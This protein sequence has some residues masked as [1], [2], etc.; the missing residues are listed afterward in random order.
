M[1]GR[2]AR[3]KKL[4]ELLK[5]EKSQVAIRLL[6]EQL[7]KASDDTTATGVE[8]SLE[9]QG[10]S[11]D[12]AKWGMDQKP[13][14]MESQESPEA[15]RHRAYL[16]QEPDTHFL[17]RRA[18]HPDSKT[19]P[20]E[21]Y[22]LGEGLTE[23]RAMN[24]GIPM[25]SNKV[26]DL[27]SNGNLNLHQSLILPSNK[28]EGWMKLKGHPEFRQHSQQHLADLYQKIASNTANATE[29]QGYHSKKITDMNPREVSMV[30]G[31]KPKV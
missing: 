29:A 30:A 12:E 16:A 25:D 8:Q 13:A 19:K 24:D 5:S 22:E 28:A 2:S 23:G 20:W 9:R 6:D 15:M 14:S 4:V 11:E 31:R 21:V 3:I 7:A 10:G 1:Q 27:I 26:K 17:N 18:P